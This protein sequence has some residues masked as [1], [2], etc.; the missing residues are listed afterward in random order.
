MESGKLVKVAT[1]ARLLSV[2]PKT[3][4]RSD[5][6]LKPLRDGNGHR[7]YD[8]DQLMRHLGRQGG[9]RRGTLDRLYLG[10]CD[11]MTALRDRSIHLAFTSPPYPGRRRPSGNSIPIK[12]WIGWMMPKVAEI[13]RV[14]R[15]DGSFVVVIREPV[16]DGERHPIVHDFVRE[17]RAEGWRF[18]DELIWVK[19]N[20]LPGRPAGRLKDAY[21]RILHFTFA[22]RYAFH[23]DQVR[24]PC[25][26]WHG[27]G[28]RERT[29]MGGFQ[30]ALDNFAGLESAY[31]SNVIQCAHVSQHLLH[32]AAHPVEL[33]DFLIRLLT[34][35]GDVVLDPFAGSGTTLVAAARLGRRWVGYEIR[36]SAYHAAMARLEGDREARC[37]AAPARESG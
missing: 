28:K 19:T 8:P 15:P 17:M 30:F 2:S 32:D 34:R 4:R 31:P 9:R 35:E 3:I 26:P 5:D 22:K 29:T 16:I 7:L 37:A 6:E 21:E 1:A 33:P 14:L 27:N 24:Q 20:P 13:R 12:S 10:S 23:P 18:V 25:K 11:R 36:R